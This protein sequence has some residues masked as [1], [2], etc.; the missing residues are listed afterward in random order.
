MPH[1]SQNGRDGRWIGVSQC[2]AEFV[3][4]HITVCRVRL[5][6]DESPA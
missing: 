4:G 5:Q 3:N 6:P 2:G 1:R